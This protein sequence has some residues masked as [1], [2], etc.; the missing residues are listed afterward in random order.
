M[1]AY[2]RYADILAPFSSTKPFNRKIINRKTEHNVLMKI[3]CVI[4][5]LVLVDKYLLPYDVQ[6]SVNRRTYL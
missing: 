1:P 6:V 4:S 2:K 5:I 3:N